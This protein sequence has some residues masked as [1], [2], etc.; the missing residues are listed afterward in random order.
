MALSKWSEGPLASFCAC[1]FCFPGYFTIPRLGNLAKEL[2]S[3]TE[4]VG[5]YL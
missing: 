5:H 4:F 1:D 2:N 3:P